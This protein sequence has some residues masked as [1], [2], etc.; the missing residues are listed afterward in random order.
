MFENLK[1]KKKITWLCSKSSKNKVHL[2]FCFLVAPKDHKNDITSGKK[3]N[4]SLH[5]LDYVQ[6]QVL[7]LKGIRHPPCLI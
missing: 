5:P 7:D 4:P 1:K 3:K 6:G 2:L